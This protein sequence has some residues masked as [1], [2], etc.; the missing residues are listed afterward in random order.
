ML[1]E[2]AIDKLIEPLV[3]RQEALNNYIVT[4]IARRI[5]EIGA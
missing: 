4:L 1:S 2:K 3:N 5:K